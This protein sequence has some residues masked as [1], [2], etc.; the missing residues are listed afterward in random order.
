MNISHEDKVS[1]GF[2]HRRDLCYGE[3]EFLHFVPLIEAMNPQKGDVF[4]DIGCGTA[5]PLVVAALAYSNFISKCKGVEL[6]E[7]LADTAKKCAERTAILSAEAEIENIP[8]IE[9]IKGDLFEYDWPKDADLVFCANVL[10]GDELN[11]R[12][13]DMMAQ[14]RKGVRVA[15]LNALPQRP[16]LK[17]YFQMITRMSWGYHTCIYYEIV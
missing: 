3:A 7:G 6:L 10:L 17:K 4:Y 1:M 13:T 5:R 14:L 15:V 2:E 8:A 9:I 16:Y 12:L 11:E